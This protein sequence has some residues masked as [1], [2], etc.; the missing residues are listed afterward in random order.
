MN[1]AQR[2]GADTPER[3]AACERL[4]ALVAQGGV[5]EIRLAWCDQ[6][7]MLRG[8]TL[9]P[10]AL[11]SALQ[12]GIGMVATIALKD[13]SDR[14][15]WK[16][17]EPGATADLPG[18]AQANNLVLL[19]DPSS[20][21]MLPWT[22]GPQQGQ[23]LAGPVAWLRCD[24][25]FQNGEPLWACTRRQLQRAIN[26][27]AGHGWAL[28]C[29]LEV[30]FHIYRVL[31]DGWDLALD[32]HQADWPGLPP[33]VQLLHPGYELL[34][35]AHAD[36]C[37]EALSIVRKTAQGLGLPLTSLEIEL[38]P[39]QFEAV[40]DVQ[41][42]LAAADGM[43]LFRNG[44]KQALARA[45]YHASFM[46]RPPFAQIMSSGWHL[47]QSVIDQ[48]G[49]SVLASEGTSLLSA[50]GQHWLAGLLAH[51]PAMSAL[52][53]PTVNGFERFRP[54]ALAP[55]RMVWGHDNRGAMLRVV[56]QPGNP[57]THFENRLGEPLANPYLY[58]ASQIWAGLDGVAQSRPLPPACDHP[59]Q[60]IPAAPAASAVPAGSIEPT[61]A[62][63]RLPS[64]LSVALE[65]LQND[66]TYL[67]GF[68]EGFVAYYAQI[69]AQEI[70]R[71]AASQDP[72]EWQR[73][74]YFGRF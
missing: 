8:K 46:C 62:T 1:F 28:R 30:E 72:M 43:V 19:P 49:Q 15:A 48:Q 40:F 5:A 37:H 29:G 13:T 70:Q 6:H 63:D 60:A 35:E 38:G 17:F 14:T 39:S 41:D 7:G 68:G 27:L 57:S 71:F 59:Y 56:G 73:R 55:Q 69:K 52:A 61:A 3:L 74:E 54:H 50:T 12:G 9:T 26:A 21:Q 25:Y 31:P 45:G 18:F 23:A 42:P 36:R 53:V 58:L 66:A 22:A 24:A 44:V 67:A 11:P 33:Q 4:I 32:P 20:L 16:V 47:H 10:A 65:H 51:A 2:C 34:G 64:S